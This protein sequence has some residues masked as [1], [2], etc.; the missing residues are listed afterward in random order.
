MGDLERMRTKIP[1]AYRKAWIVGGIGGVIGAGAGGYLA[2]LKGNYLYAG[3]GAGL[4]ILA[5]DFI[6]LLISRN[7]SLP[8]LALVEEKV[9]FLGGILGLLLAVAGIFGFFLT[10]KWIGIVGAIFFGLC[11]IYLL[12]IR[13]REM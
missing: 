13:G 2:Y 1:A 11:G 5:G 6:G 3:L 7:L 4:G 9:N 10:G 8:R 12:A